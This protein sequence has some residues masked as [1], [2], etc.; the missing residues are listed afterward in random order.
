MRKASPGRAKQTS[1]RADIQAADGQ[2]P[3]RRGPSPAQRVSAEAFLQRVLAD[4]PLPK[5][6]V[7]ALAED[8]G[9]S[10]RTVERAAGNIGVR[11]DGRPGQPAIWAM[12]PSAT[13]SESEKPG[14]LADG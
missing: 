4:G 11:S 6:R 5:Q 10:V 14:E 9:H 8:G 12:P 3:R 2:T 7:L 1:A 13:T